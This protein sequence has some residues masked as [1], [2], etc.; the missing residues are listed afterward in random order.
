MIK[1]DSNEVSATQ[2]AGCDPHV[3]AEATKICE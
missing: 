3:M 1:K 2:I